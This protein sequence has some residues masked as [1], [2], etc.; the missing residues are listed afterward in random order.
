MNSLVHWTWLSKELLNLRIYTETSRVEKQSKNTKKEKK[1]HTHTHTENPRNEGQLS[2]MHV[3]GKPEE[4]GEEGG[5][6]GEE[7]EKGDR[8]RR[9]RRRQNTNI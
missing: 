8:E 3:L 6:R 5:R 2:K 4:L 9:R 1:M 7:D